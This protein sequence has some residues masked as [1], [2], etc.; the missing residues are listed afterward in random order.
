[1]ESERPSNATP[2]PETLAAAEALAAPEVPS[3]PPPSPGFGE[4][5]SRDGGTESDG[6]ALRRRSKW[7]K[8][9]RIKAYERVFVVEPN[10]GYYDD[11]QGLR[12]PDKSAT[13]DTTQVKALLAEGAP[14]L[15]LF[16]DKSDVI[17]VPHGAHLACREQCGALE[18]VVQSDA[19]LGVLHLRSLRFLVLA[20]S[21]DVVAT[22][23]PDCSPLGVPETLSSEA[24]DRALERCRNAYPP[25]R[26]IHAVNKVLLLPYHVP[27]TVYLS[28]KLKIDSL[29]PAPSPRPTTARTRA[30]SNEDA[31]SLGGR[32][33][34]HQHVSRL[35]PNALKRSVSGSLSARH[36]KAK[37]HDPSGAHADHVMTPEFD[38]TVGSM[39]LEDLLGELTTYVAEIEKGLSRR[40]YFY[41]YDMD[42]TRSLQGQ[43]AI[44]AETGRLAL[45]QP[46]PLWGALYGHR[47]RTLLPSLMEYCDK[48]FCWNRALCKPLEEFGVDLA[49]CTP[50]VQGSVSSSLVNFGNSLLRM[51]LIGRRGSGRGGTRYFARGINHNGDVANFCESEFLA[52]VTLENGNQS[53]PSS[54]LKQSAGGWMAFLQ[55]RGSVPLYWEQNSFGINPMPKVT[56]TILQSKHCVCI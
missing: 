40:S 14:E 19:F 37:S 29:R 31:R 23:P 17:E 12:R 36:R 33:L 2:K 27:T 10:L 28:V 18:C 7:T 9:W 5:V 46:L 53:F 43:S 41:S 16:R 21:S 30:P 13:L 11:P 35:P 15:L 47:D 38:W 1:M 54:S 26:H 52:N 39:S 49:W 8:R 34:S 56:G 55:I 22:L 24:E 4:H 32:R 20:V 44:Y 50:L 6:A 3:A 48:Q 42:L 51:V 25:E 45:P